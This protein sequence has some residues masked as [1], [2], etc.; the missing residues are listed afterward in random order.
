MATLKEQILEIVDEHSGGLKGLELMTAL[1]EKNGGN[2]PLDG[3]NFYDEIEKELETIPELGILKY[4]MKLN[5]NLYREKIFIYRKA[6]IF[7]MCQ[8]EGE[9]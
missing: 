3:A 9:E 7:H 5:D 1:I 6:G 2:L 8:K 4:G